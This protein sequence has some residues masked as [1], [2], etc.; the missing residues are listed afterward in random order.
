MCP[1]LRI[2]GAR[3]TEG[4]FSGGSTG[5]PSL[6]VGLPLPALLSCPPRPTDTPLQVPVAGGRAQVLS[7]LVD[8]ADAPYPTRLLH[9]V[10]GTT[11]FC[12]CPAGRGS[13]SGLVPHIPTPSPLGGL[14]QSGGSPDCLGVLP[15]Q[16]P[17]TRVDESHGNGFSCSSEINLQSEGSR[18][19]SL[20]PLSAP[21]GPRRS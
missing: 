6:A 14:S 7:R 12:S 11:R 9:R 2:G 13:H 17:T 8:M 10:S 3:G 19:G 5:V 18:G 4:N 21:G 1:R 15:K 20:L 16:S